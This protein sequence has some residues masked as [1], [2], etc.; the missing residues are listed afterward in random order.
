MDQAQR[1]FFT[2]PDQHGGQEGVILRL[3]ALKHAACRLFFLQTQPDRIR[4]PAEA[5]AYLAHPQVRLIVVFAL[6]FGI[7]RMIGTA[8]GTFTVGLILIRSRR[9]AVA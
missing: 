1:F 2:R 5:N 6:T 7:G 9:V 3:I 8:W 4:M